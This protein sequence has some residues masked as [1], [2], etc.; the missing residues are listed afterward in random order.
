MITKPR[1]IDALDTLAQAIHDAVTRANILNDLD[2][3]LPFQVGAGNVVATEIGTILARGHGN[4]AIGLWPLPAKYV[5]RYNPDDEPYYTPPQVKLTAAVDENVITFSGASVARY[6]VHTVLDGI[7]DAVIQ[8]SPLQGLDAVAAAVAAQI[9][10][11]GLPG[12]SATSVGPAVTIDGAFE[13]FCNVGGAGTLSREVNRISR[14]IVASVYSPDALTRTSVGET[15]MS[16]VGTTLKHWYFMSDG[17]GLYAMQSANSLR[18]E[19]QDS[20]SSFEYHIT[21]ETE[22]PI[23]STVALVQVGVVES[24][25]SVTPNPS[26][27]TSF[28]GG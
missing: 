16:A 7:G 15:I 9:N 19:A 27:V 11:L 24:V 18:E 22:Y 20:Y 21:F 28:I 5:T 1:L 23:T 13:V 25:V 8:T 14:G 17:Q 3:P 12:V 10:A 4:T 6:N 2:Q 26:P